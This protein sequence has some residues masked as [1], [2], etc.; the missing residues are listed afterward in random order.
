MKHLD[1]ICLNF[2]SF[3]YDALIIVSNAIR[4]KLFPLT[5]RKYILIK[6]F[7]LLAKIGYQVSFRMNIQIF[8]TL[9]G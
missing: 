1:M 4:K 9:C 8:I 6:L 5:I 7:Y 3:L 2:P